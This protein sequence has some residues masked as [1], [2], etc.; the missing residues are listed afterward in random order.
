MLQTTFLYYLV[1][2]DQYKSL[3][4]AAEKI[5]VTQPALSKGIKALEEQVGVPLLE[6]SYKGVTLTQEGKQLAERAKQVLNM[7]E[8]METM[9]SNEQKEPT[10]ALLQDYQLYIHPNYTPQI[11]NALSESYTDVW[12]NTYQILNTSSAKNI[13]ETLAEHKNA[14]ILHILPE[15]YT[16]SSDVVM[17]ILRKSKPYL[18]CTKEFLKITPEQK[19]ISLKQILQIPLAIPNEHYD[20]QATMLDLLNQH[21][22]PQIAIILPNAHSIPS[23]LKKNQ[24]AS[25][26]IRLFK[27]SL[28]N[29]RYITIRNAPNFNLA[30]L[31]N[32]Q[33]SPVVI[34]HL[35]NVLE[36][37][38]I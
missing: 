15:D 19:S 38:L 35:Q 5:H 37:Y 6:R 32:K 13:E 23:V 31:Y 30:L 26:G 22:T 20:Y 18:M 36:P 12:A 17:R 2:I 16:P 21:G 8:D 28:A 24:A 10:P 14:I 4:V 33:I 29:L 9:F 11:M 1:Q 7:L 25:F 3:S 34:D 27:E